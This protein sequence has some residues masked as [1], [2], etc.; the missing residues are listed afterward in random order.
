VHGQNGVVAAEKLNGLF[1]LAREQ[2]NAKVLPRLT[3]GLKV[4]F[5]IR[6]GHETLQVGKDLGLALGIVGH[7]VQADPEKI[8]NVDSDLAVRLALRLAATKDIPDGALVDEVACLGLLVARAH[9]RRRAGD[10]AILE[11]GQ[12]I[13]QQ[14]SRL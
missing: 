7:H 3:V 14:L 1:K 13:L 9:L 4:G 8:L 10:L 6:L 2:Q 5:A 12:G 11:G